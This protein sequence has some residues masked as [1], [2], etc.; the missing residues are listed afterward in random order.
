[1]ARY[2]VGDIQ[3]CLDP[4]NKLLEQVRFDPA[5]DRLFCVGDL[6]NRGP[7]SLATLRFLKTLGTSVETVLGNHDMH[8]LAIYYGD[9][10]VGAS[11]TLDDI[12]AAPDC[13]E[14]C[15]W[16]RTRPMLIENRQERHLIVHAGVPHIWNRTTTLARAKELED[17]MRGS[18]HIR[19]FRHIYGDHP[20]IW[21][22]GLRGIERLRVI[23]N[24]LSRMRLISDEGRLKLA[25]KA[26][27]NNLPEGYFPWFER[28]HSDWQGYKFFF[29]HWASIKGQTG[30]SWA[31]ALDTGCV[32]GEHLCLY[33]LE[34]EKRFYCPCPGTG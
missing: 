10:A 6:I 21:H 9:H 17:A 28:R 3:G 14:L 12:L 32:W 7:Q 29:G 23:T 31:Q 26:G 27:L 8:L 1:M 20:T 16:L 34:D 33:R 15:T 13:D 11:D 18:D 5:C 2:I 4:L 22:S 25:Y 19:Y 30:S 24:Y